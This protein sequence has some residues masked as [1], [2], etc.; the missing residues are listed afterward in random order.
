MLYGGSG[1]FSTCESFLKVKYLGFLP[2]YKLSKEQING[3]KL[4]ELPCH[5]WD[6][7]FFRS[8]R[9][10]MQIEH[11]QNDYSINPIILEFWHCSI[12]E[13]SDALKKNGF[14]FII[15]KNNKD[16]GWFLIIN[17]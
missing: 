1:T 4:Y 2:W 13:L 11:C 7:L 12:E 17:K 16:N 6:Y 5:P 3:I 10:R 14:Q 15:D 9:L 8:K